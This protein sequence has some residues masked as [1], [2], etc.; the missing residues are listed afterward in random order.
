MMGKRTSSRRALFAALAGVATVVAHPA[1]AGV[2]DKL[3]DGLFK[4][5]GSEPSTPPLACYVSEDGRL[6]TLDRTQP[7]PMMK[8][9][10]SPEVFALQ[11]SMAPRGDVIYRN[12]LGEPVL[13]ATRL[14]GFTLFTDER[15]TGE[16]V[17]LAG[18]CAPL[19][20]VPLSPQALGDRMLQASFRA[21]RAARHTIVFQAEATPASSA[22]IGDAAVVV[23]LAIVHTAQRRDGDEL[24]TKVRKVLFEEGKKASAT[25]SAGVLRVVISPG[26]GLAGRPSSDRIERVLR[27]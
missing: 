24:L 12:D 26:Q 4:H 23:T 9:E 14:G 19:R 8:F 6:F 21:G 18:A 3:R 7:V 25:L 1:A 17:S 16:A 22:L 20:L 2:A 11:A 27:K 15:P 5:H 10:D 13:R